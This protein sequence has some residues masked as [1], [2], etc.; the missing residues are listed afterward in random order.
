MKRRRSA[1]FTGAGG[2]FCAGAD[3]KAVAAGDPNKKREIGGHD[4]I[5]PMGPASRP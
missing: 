3:L 5:A 4:L 2:Y 1:V